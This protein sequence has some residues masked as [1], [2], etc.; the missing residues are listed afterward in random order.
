MSLLPEDAVVGG[1][2]DVLLAGVDDA[3]DKAGRD[4]DAA[5]GASAALRKLE[6][7]SRR[8]RGLVRGDARVK[9]YMFFLH[10]LRRP[11]APPRRFNDAI[12]GV[13]LA[14]GSVGRGP[15]DASKFDVLK[16]ADVVNDRQ[17][18]AE[19]L[20]TLDVIQVERRC[21]HYTPTDIPLG[22]S[23]R[24][25]AF[26]GRARMLTQHVARR[27]PN[28]SRVCDLATCAHVFLHEP[29]RAAAAPVPPSGAGVHP[30]TTTTTG[31][32]ETSDDDDD[33]DDFYWRSLSSTTSTTSPLPPKIFCSH[34][35]ASSFDEEV[36][37]AIP[38]TV[39]QFDDSDDEHLTGK[40][41]LSRTVAA[42]RSAFKRNDAAARTLREAMRAF[43]RKANS[44]L[45][46][47]TVERMHR[48][49]ADCLN[50]DLALLFA[51]AALAE[52]PPSAARRLLPGTNSRWRRDARPWL[53]A[54]ARIRVLMSAHQKSHE[55]VT[56][57]QRMPPRWLCKVR[58]E[59]KT[60]FRLH[61]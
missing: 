48:D 10:A 14:M 7:V 46:L 9:Y 61:Q 35:C 20:L 22:V 25:A 45:S 24:V 17:K 1:L 56:A 29:T 34:A 39:D 59:A 13:T 40:V 27:H 38:I 12:F 8:L 36:R 43:K 26:L 23:T 49:V 47:A 15:R 50:V 58:D 5:L 54:V 30:A 42:L 44:T 31:V 57:D 53:S 55:G 51:A 28:C 4:V 18:T 21:S 33:D 19:K 37:A 2:V 16:P 32:D 6:R 41:G 60:L 11:H 52:S 3:T